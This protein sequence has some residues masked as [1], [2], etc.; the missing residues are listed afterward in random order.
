MNGASVFLLGGI[1]FLMVTL[2]IL[3]VTLYDYMSTKKL[4]KYGIVTYGE[5]EN[6]TEGFRTPYIEDSAHQHDHLWIKFNIEGQERH[7]YIAIPILSKTQQAKKFATGSKKKI[8]VLKKKKGIY[9]ARLLKENQENVSYQKP[10]VL[11]V[12]SVFL[13]SISVFFFLNYL[14][15]KDYIINSSSNNNVN[16]NKALNNPYIEK[17]VTLNDETIESMNTKFGVQGRLENPDISQANYVWEI[18]ND[19]KIKGTIN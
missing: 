15:Y 1:S 11:T 9:E 18:K 3:S 17:F 2:L 16:Y 10:I 6:I 7:T 19:M 8:K 12:I 5:I 4:N 13:L 14:S